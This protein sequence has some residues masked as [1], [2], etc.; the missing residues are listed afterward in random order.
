MEIVYVER[1]NRIDLRLKAD[2]NDGSGMQ[3]QPLAAVNKMEVVVGGV[4]VSSENGA[5]DVIR[6]AQSGYATGEVRMWLGRYT[7]KVG[8]IDTYLPIGR[9]DAPLIVYDPSNAHGIMW[10]H[11]PIL[12]KSTGSE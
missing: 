7:Y 11:V 1:D 5:N 2:L 10:E 6:W 8:L 4:T 3:Y 9:Y 12:V